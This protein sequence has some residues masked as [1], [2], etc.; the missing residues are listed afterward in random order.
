MS[1]GDAVPPRPSRVAAAAWALWDWGSAAFNAVITTFVFVPYLARAVA[2]AEGPVSGT[3]YVA[4]AMAI[5]GLVILVFAPVMGQ[6]ADARGRRRSSLGVWSALTWLIMFSL[7]AIKDSPDYLLA[8]LVL[9][10]LGNVCFQFAEVNYFAMLPQVSTPANVGRVSGLGWGMGYFGGIVLLALVYFGLIAP[11]VGWFGVTADEG[12]K[13]RVVAVGAAVWFMIFGLPVLFAVPR[14][15]PPP[16][17]R[18]LGPI[19]AYRKLY[20]DVRTLWQTRRSAVW[21]LLASAL[22]RDGLAG[23]FTFG[24]VLAVTVYG[25]SESQVLI[26]GI[27]ANVVAGLAAVIGGRIE[28]RVGPK[29]VIMASLAL[30]VGAGTVLLFVSGPTMFWIFGLILCLAVGPAQASSRSYLARL[31]PRGHEGEMFGL[32]A[33]TGRAV[34]FVGPALFAAFAAW[35]GDR[36]GTLGI[37]VLLLA[38]GLLLWR[39]PNTPAAAPDPAVGDGSPSGRE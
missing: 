22:Y 26:F 24:A 17:S 23:V 36:L 37:V 31:A 38:G 25:L 28:D 11:E 9:I 14:N 39:L 19:A 29:P 32:Y 1:D 15:V 18:P 12:M 3:E 35:G 30:L 5:T 21:F 7:F 8:G 16:G 27:A 13:Y 33:T 4:R 10:G 34:S 2:P 6:R 20:A